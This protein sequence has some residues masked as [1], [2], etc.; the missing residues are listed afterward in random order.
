MPN[1]QHLRLVRRQERLER[2]KR[3]GFGVVV[4]RP[5]P[6]S[7]S[8]KLSGELDGAI[9]EQQKRRKPDYIDPSL[10]LR[11]RMDGYEHEVDWEGAGLTVLSTDVDRTLVLFS[12]TDDL[13]DFRRKLAEYGGPLKAGNK[14]PSHAGFIGSIAEIGDIEARD[15]IGVRF[16]EIGFTEPG[17]FRA[18]DL[19]LVD[20]ELWDTGRKEARERKASQ[21]GK[22]IESVGGEHYDTYVGP[23]L[24]V[25]RARVN[26]KALRTVLDLTDVASVD[27]PPQPDLATQEAIDLTLS[28]LPPIEELA[29]TAPVIAVLDSGVNA[30][31]LIDPFLVAAIGVPE[32][33]G[34]ADEFGH[35]TRV[36]GIG[37]YGDLRRQ[38]ES[39]Q[40]ASAA[41]LAMA[42]V[43]NERG[44]FEDRRLVPS[45]MDE[46][47][48]RLHGEYGARIFIISLGDVNRV[49]D[50]GKVGAWAA[51]L[52]ELARELD[53]LIVVSAGNRSPRGGTRFE[54]G[55]TEYPTYL[56]E[57]SNRLLEPAGA[58]NVLTVGALAHG[59]GLAEDAADD[60]RMR[61]ITQALEPAP[62]SRVGLGIGGSL[63]PDFVDLGGTMIVDPYVQRMRQ[64]D[65]YPS[66]GMLTLHH[67]QFDRLFTAGSGTSY[68]GPMVANKAAQLLTLLPDASANLLRALMANAASIPEAA[69]ERL[70]GL[71]PGDLQRV[72]GNGLVDPVKASYSDDHRVVLYADDVLEVDYFAVYAI[73]VPDTF[74]GGGRRTLRV[75]LAY[76]PPVRHT[77]S[78]YAGISMSFRVIRG[79]E[80]DVIFEHFRARAKAEGKF[81]EIPASNNCALRPGPEERERGTLQTASVEFVRD[82]AHHGDT[83]YLVVRCEGGWAAPTTATQKFAVVVEMEH[84]TEL[85]L[86]ARLQARLRA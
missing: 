21:I 29:A 5:Q 82:T 3:P 36:S 6:K 72:C 14:N 50:G 17:D 22:Y 83:Y 65:T 66:A 43:V 68:A 38:I 56:T 27:M 16:R 28:E 53:V 47:I 13:A 35:G 64:G 44:A 52:D 86:Y 57:A 19:L 54:Q 78:D 24:T 9:A 34:S 61:P 20:I 79:M 8:D 51:T 63:K 85:Q 40:F 2:R 33:L 74:Q 10:I 84:Q 42:K 49:Y 37:L 67:R 15:R 32:S 55:V 30:H 23:S 71:Q 18:E 70:R 12:S 11:V 69:V 45:Q 60:I 31:P 77:R 4:A 26:G 58:I 73:P 7:H 76:D 39:G 1:Y 62:F 41:R 48:R 59:P 46:A 75:S 25:L 81:P 80:P